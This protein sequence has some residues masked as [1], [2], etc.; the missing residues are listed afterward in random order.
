MNTLFDDYDDRK[1]YMTPIENWEHLKIQIKKKSKSFANT[2]ANQRKLQQ[3][4]IDQNKDKII[5]PLL[6]EHIQQKEKELQNFINLGNVIRAKNNIVTKIYEEGKE[7]N[8]KQEIKNG[9]QKFIFQ[10]KRNDEVL[11]EKG[12]IILEIHNY[13]QN[14]YTSQKIKN[15][16]IDNYLQDFDP[17]PPPQT[18]LI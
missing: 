1:I 11:Y 15:N 4:F 18:R 6:K 14:L 17:P 5:D 13:Y 7:I 10:I 8:R 12:E 3:H 16:D 2:K 9:N